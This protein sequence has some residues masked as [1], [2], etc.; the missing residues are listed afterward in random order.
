MAAPKNRTQ[1]ELPEKLLLT[2]YEAALYSGIG[3]NR[4]R[5]LA[6]DSNCEWSIRVGNKKHMIIREKFEEYIR[7]IKSI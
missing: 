4:L 2:Y 6:T 1:V 3:I 7:N 5:R